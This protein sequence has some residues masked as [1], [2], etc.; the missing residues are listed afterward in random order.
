MNISSN[1]EV[2]PCE[3][4]KWLKNKNLRL[5]VYNLPINCIWRNDTLLNYLRQNRIPS[6]CSETKCSV[7]GTCRGGCVGQTMLYTSK[8]EVIKYLEYNKTRVS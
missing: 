4:F 8:D 7:L 2:F 1:G 3:A 5:N 6:Y